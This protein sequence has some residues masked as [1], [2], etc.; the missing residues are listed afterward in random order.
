MTQAEIRETRTRRQTRRPDYVYNEA[1]SSEVSWTLRGDVFLVTNTPT[2][3]P[4]DDVDEYN[5]EEDDDDDA[6]EQNG[7]SDLHADNRR[8]GR[9]SGAKVQR[10][11]T[12]IT[13][14]K[15]PSPEI[16]A[17]EWRGERRSSRL[18]ALEDVQLDRPPKR[19][20]T[21]ESTTSSGSAG[22]NVSPPSTSNAN[23]KPKMNGAAAVKPNEIAME[24]VGRKKKSKFW[25]YAVEPIPAHGSNGWSA[26][27]G[28]TALDAP[29]NHDRDDHLEPP[30][31][32]NGLFATD[33]DP[34]E[35]MGLGRHGSISPV[36]QQCPP[37]F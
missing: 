27:P 22:W 31:N 30:G 9:A 12:R 18:G 7:G 26:A 3:L 5:F 32:S 17:H 28:S 35:G 15:R 8:S 34:G 20:R 23:P 11:S 37:L 1:E 25:F 4:Q 21:E 2:R 24:Q 36:Q 29:N 33:H 10:R 13:K 6:F 19:A 14:G 16:S